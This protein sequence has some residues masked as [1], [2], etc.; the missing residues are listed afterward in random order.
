MFSFL[1]NLF[2]FKICS[3]P[4]FVLFLKF[5]SLKKKYNQS[6][7][8]LKIKNKKKPRK[9]KRKNTTVP[10]LVGLRPNKLLGARGATLGADQL[11]I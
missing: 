9:R 7:N 4:K 11:G 1:K 10:D 2:Q 3:V 6:S 5:V 8:F